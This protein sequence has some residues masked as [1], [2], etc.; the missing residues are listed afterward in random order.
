MNVNKKQKLKIYEAL[1]DKGFLTETDIFN[2]FNIENLKEATSIYS[3]MLQ[4][5]MEGKASVSKINKEYIM[6][7]PEYAVKH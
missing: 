6:Y 2:M 1:K 4:M 7:M 3:V 5:E